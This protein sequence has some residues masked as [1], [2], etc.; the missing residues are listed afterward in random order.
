MNSNSIRTPLPHAGEDNVKV[1][2]PR[3]DTA[4]SVLLCAVSACGILTL[5]SARADSPPLRV[6]IDSS[7]PTAARDRVVADRVAKQAGLTLT[8]KSFNGS[9]DDDGISAKEFRTLL[10]D[11]CELVMGYPLDT[12]GPVLPPGLLATKP[13]AQTGFVLVTAPGETARNLSDLPN[14]TEVAVTYETAPNLYFPDHGNVLPDVHTSDAETMQ[15]VAKGLVKAAMI[16][17]PTVD[18]YQLHPGAAKLG[19]YPLQEPH[20]RY[21]VVA[22]YLPKAAHQADS[23]NATKISVSV[24]AAANSAGSGLPALFTDTQAKVGYAKFLGNCAQCHGTHLEGRSGPSLKGPNWA[25]AKADYTVGEVFTV[26]SQQMPATNPGSLEH[27]DY[28]QIMAFL[29][30][31]NGYPAGSTPLQFDKAVASKVPLLYHG[32]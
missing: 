5:Q 4:R 26:V 23:F 29:L 20:A 2:R 6:C 22:L 19:V 31:Q 30:Q 15:A 3:I 18:E 32:G 12:S 11:F 25:N 10:S 24:P 21:D 9:G 7:S 28:E 27:V 14:G 13:Y 16:W 8:V 17:Q 1:S